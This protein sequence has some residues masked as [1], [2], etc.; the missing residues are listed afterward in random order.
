M[1]IVISRRC[2]RADVLSHNVSQVISS[3]YVF[4]L[5]DLVQQE[6][7]IYGRI[8]LDYLELLLLSFSLLRAAGF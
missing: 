5:L 8:N 7:V 4:L 6:Q 2:F 1:S 3:L